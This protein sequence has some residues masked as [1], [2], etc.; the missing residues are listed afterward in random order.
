MFDKFFKKEETAL[1]REINVRIENLCITNGNPEEDAKAV[2]NL[3]KL[4][5]I[6][7]EREKPRNPIN[8]NTIIAGLFTVGTAVLMLYYEKSDV[9][10][11]KVMSILPKPKM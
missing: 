7:V 3:R 9:I 2:E 8:P 1:E 10:T 11:S 4:T 5:E 6:Q